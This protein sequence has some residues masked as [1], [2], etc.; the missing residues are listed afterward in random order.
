M[1]KNFCKFLKKMRSSDYLKQ[2]AAAHLY[3]KRH[4][5]KQRVYSYTQNRHFQNYIISDLWGILSRNF[6]DTF[7]GHMGLILHLVKRGIIG[8]LYT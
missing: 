6:T 5:Q 8:L 7:W 4:A 3:L 2:G 1:K